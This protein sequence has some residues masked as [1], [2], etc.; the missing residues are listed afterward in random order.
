MDAGVPMAPTIFAFKGKR[1]PAELMQQIKAR[2]WK[3]FVM[4]QSESGFSLGFFKISVDA[5]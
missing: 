4:K 5:C 3:S 1:S 2:G